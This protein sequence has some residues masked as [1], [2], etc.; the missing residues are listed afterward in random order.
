MVTVQA[1]QD[2]DLTKL[3]VGDSVLATYL[4]AE[5]IGMTCDGK[6]VK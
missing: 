1:K 4:V 6:L 3:K 5:A 2:I